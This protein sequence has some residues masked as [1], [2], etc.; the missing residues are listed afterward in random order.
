[1]RRDATPRP[2]Q[3]G[4]RQ[5]NSTTPEIVP[6]P[7][8]KITC[9]ECGAPTLPT[10]GDRCPKCWRLELTDLRLERISRMTEDW[11]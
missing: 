5:N 2:R 7:L 1:M 4:E 11:R 10:C 3:P 6:L 8:N 9:R